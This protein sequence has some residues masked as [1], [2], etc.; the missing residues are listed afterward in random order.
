MSLLGIQFDAS[1][2]L[3]WVICLALL[4]GGLLLL[5]A[6]APQSARKLG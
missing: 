2:T 4:I 3:P 6:I 1:N 5:R